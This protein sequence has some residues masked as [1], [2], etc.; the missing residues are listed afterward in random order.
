M[1]TDSTQQKPW[2][3]QR[4]PWLLMIGPAWVIVGGI[5]MTYLALGTPDA[6]VVDDYYK[7]GKAINQ[8]LRRDEAAARLQLAF[9]ANYSPARATLDGS[10]SQAGKPLASALHLQLVHSTQPEKDLKLE[11]RSGPDG[12]FSVPLPELERARWSVLVEGPERDWRLSGEWKWPEQ[13][14]VSLKAY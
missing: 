1:K 5:I 10:V 4:W 12:R 8:D 9:D 11:V 13:R 6:L 3:K 7:R 2:Y 14:A